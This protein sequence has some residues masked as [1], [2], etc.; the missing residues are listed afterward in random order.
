MQLDVVCP[1]MLEALKHIHWSIDPSHLYDG[2]REKEPHVTV[3]YGLRNDDEHAYRGL[4]LP[5]V[6]WG[7]ANLSAFRNP[8]C[9]VLKLSVHGPGTHHLRDLLMRRFPTAPQTFKTYQPHV[10][11]AY[12]K[13]GM[14]KHYTGLDVP[15][16]LTVSDHLTVH[17]RDRKA[18]RMDLREPLSL[19]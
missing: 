2:G 16:C 17:T 5:K 15:A 13:P 11:I 10:T 8:K 12:L 19:R 7:F 1:K 3:L 6:E 9:D 18:Y 4:S 14:S